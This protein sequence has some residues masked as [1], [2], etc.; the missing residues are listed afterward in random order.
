MVGQKLMQL[1]VHFAQYFT[2]KML[3]KLRHITVS[4]GASGTRA[5]TPNIYV[6]IIDRLV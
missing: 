5:T 6:D 3:Y 1:G 4:L 2:D